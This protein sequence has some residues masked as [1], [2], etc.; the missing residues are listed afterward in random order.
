MMGVF[1]LGT[2]PVVLAIA[3]FL[4][5]WRVWPWRVYEKSEPWVIL[6]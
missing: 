2:L 3:V 4:L 6:R 1:G 5:G